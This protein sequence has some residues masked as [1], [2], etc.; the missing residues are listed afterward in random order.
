MNVT[1][2]PRPSTTDRQV[3]SVPPAAAG[4][5]GAPAGASTD[6]RSSLIVEHHRSSESSLSTPATSAASCHLGNAAR[7]EKAACLQRTIK[8]IRSA[9]SSMSRPSSFS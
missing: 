9:S 5:A 8:S 6:R 1:I 4:A 2:R 7:S 3:V